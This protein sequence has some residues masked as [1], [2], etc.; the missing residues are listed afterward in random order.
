MKLTK[1]KNINNQ[2]EIDFFD[3]SIVLKLAQRF[4]LDLND[5]EVKFIFKNEFIEFL[6]Q[7]ESF[8]KIDT[9]GVEP[10]HFPLSK[11]NNENVLFDDEQEEFGTLE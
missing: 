3:E 2:K 9:D 5:Q 6:K 11:I 1:S 10:M 7:V 4:F 8:K